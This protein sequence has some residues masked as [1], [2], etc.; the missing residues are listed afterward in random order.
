MSNR[1]ITMPIKIHQWYSE[2]YQYGKKE[3][4][5]VQKKLS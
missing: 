5:D 3:G 2:T 4:I 1:K